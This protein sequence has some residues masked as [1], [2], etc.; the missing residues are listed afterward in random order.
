MRAR[1][2]NGLLSLS[3]R[4]GL[5]H[6]A[7]FASPNLLTVLNYHRVDDPHVPGFDTL[8]VNVSATPSDFARQMDYVRKHY[9]A[10]NCETLISFLKGE[11]DLPP[12]AALIT[13]DDGYYDNY[14]N[15]FPI[16]AERNLPAVIFLATGFID[17]S[18]S[19]YWDYVSY[20]FYH[21]AKRKA[22]LP[23]L[24]ECAWE[25]EPSRER[26]LLRWIEAVKRIPE[27]QK[28]EYVSRIGAALEVDVP[29]QAFENLHL[30]WDQ[31]RAMS[32]SGL[33]EFGSHTVTHPILTRIPVEQAAYEILESRKRIEEETGRAVRALAYPNGGRADFSEPVM[34]AARDAGIEV[35][36]SLL[37]GP[38]RYST[39]GKNALS[40][41][42]IFLAHYD[43]FPRFLAKINGL[44]RLS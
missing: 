35:A 31:V 41:R 12:R 15:A 32:R 21:T 33:I 34:Q 36:F 24:G 42:R 9:S 29:A 43:T 16:L 44:S 19:F 2:V 28:N 11:A 13:F 20:C 27:T 4:M 37:P 23:L 5:Y 18:A 38:T 7:R 17:G 25:D 8:K 30:N 14:S 26:L 1:I 40:I 22:S 3:S 6:A 10:I 39:A